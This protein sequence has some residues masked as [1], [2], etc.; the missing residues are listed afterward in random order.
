[1]SDLSYPALREY[2][3]ERDLFVVHGFTLTVEGERFPCCWT[4]Y[5]TGYRIEVPPNESE[6]VR[7][8]DRNGALAYEDGWADAVLFL[9][10][11]FQ[12]SWGDAVI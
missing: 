4:C 6:P 12:K 8:F 1:M 7:I 3:A 5:A 11:R 10:E 9:E 2:L